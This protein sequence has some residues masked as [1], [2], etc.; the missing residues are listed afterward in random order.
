MYLDK[1]SNKI[2]SCWGINNKGHCIIKKGKKE[3][4]NN[5]LKE[6]KEQIQYWLD[7]KTDK[8]VEVIQLFYDQT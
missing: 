8:T 1:E 7:N 6:L 4:W 2:T 3:E 5:R